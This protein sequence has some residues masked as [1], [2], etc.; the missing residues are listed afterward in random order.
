MDDDYYGYRWIKV[1]RY[2]MDESLTWEQRYRQLEQHH[3][4]ETTFLIDKVRELAS[5]LD[6][7]QSSDG[8]KVE[9]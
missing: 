9:Q 2:V 6:E 5:R 7:L 3:L 4:E 8:P 1:K